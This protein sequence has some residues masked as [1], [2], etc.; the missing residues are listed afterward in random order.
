MTKVVR[1]GSC[2]NESATDH[3]EPLV[4]AN[5]DFVEPT[6]LELCS[7]DVSKNPLPQPQLPHH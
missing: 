7:V 4:V 5:A 3:G 6:A 2:L 1:R